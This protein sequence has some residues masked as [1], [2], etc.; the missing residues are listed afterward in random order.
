MTFPQWYISMNIHTR[1]A[2]F[3]A[4][5]DIGQVTACYINLF[6]IKNTQSQFPCIRL[7][8]INYT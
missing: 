6:L 8:K 7:T 4:Y 2:A 1:N 3:K 5:V